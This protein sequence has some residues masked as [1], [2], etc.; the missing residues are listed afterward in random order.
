MGMNAAHPVSQ[1][2]LDGEDQKNELFFSSGS[3]P[4]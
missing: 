1:R 4:A 2:V 3:H